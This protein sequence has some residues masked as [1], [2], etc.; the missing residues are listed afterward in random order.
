MA[1]YLSH[2]VQFGQSQA[3]EP[4]G[5]DRRTPGSPKGGMLW[6]D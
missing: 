1:V 6:V 3:P 5:L 4:E 2:S